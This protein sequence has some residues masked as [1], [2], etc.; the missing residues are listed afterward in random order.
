MLTSTLIICTKDRAGD[1]QRCLDSVVTQ[2]RLPDELI[3]VDSGSDDT[4]TRVAAFQEQA[5]SCKVEYLRSEP[6]LTKQRNVGIAHAH[7]DIV[8]FLDDDVILDSHYM[9]EIQKTYENDTQGDLVAVSPVLTLPRPVGQAACAFRAL[10]MLSR[11]N[12][13]GRL[14]PSGFGTYTW[15]S[16]YPDIHPL[17]VGCGCC[18]FRRSLF[19]ALRFDEWFE[20]YGYMEDLEF[21]YR[22]GKCGRFLCNPRATMLHVET[23][24]ARTNRRRLME[25]QIVNHHYMFRKHVP[26]SLFHWACFWWSEFGEGIRRAISFLKTG[27][28]DIIKGT[29]AG[30]RAILFNP[31]PRPRRA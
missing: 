3:V 18:T 24:S 12:G 19:D 8:H 31:E 26:Q 1:L 30:Y 6:G 2:T 7:N 21:T 20:G 25:M 27:D 9:D 15:Y 13:S 11:V 5:P 17:E 29:L 10:F 23:P 14:Q 4:A 22:A 28:L 16:N